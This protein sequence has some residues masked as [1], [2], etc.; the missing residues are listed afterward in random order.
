MEED[1]DRYEEESENEEG[2][3][4]ATGNEDYSSLLN[5]APEW[6]VGVILY[7]G[8]AYPLAKSKFRRSEYY[9]SPSCEW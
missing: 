9:F 6:S 4:E 8:N 7:N 5:K 3:E 1:E 2:N